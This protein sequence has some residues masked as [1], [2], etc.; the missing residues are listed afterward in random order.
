MGAVGLPS[1]AGFS[2]PEHLQLYIWDSFQMSVER[3]F[4]VTT[5]T[6]VFRLMRRTHCWPETLAM[7]QGAQLYMDR[8]TVH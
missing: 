5:P 4:S 7:E 2:F 6:A 1:R 3:A 8:S